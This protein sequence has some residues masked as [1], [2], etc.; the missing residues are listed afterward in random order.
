MKQIADTASA[1]F[2]PSSILTF[3]D[4]TLLSASPLHTGEY[5][6]EERIKSG[7]PKASCVVCQKSGGV[8]QLSVNA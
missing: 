8:M 4:F 5:A 2:H 7:K 3:I 6:V 1:R